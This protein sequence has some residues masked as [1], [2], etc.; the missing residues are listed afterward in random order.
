MKKSKSH[1]KLHPKKNITADYHTYLGLGIEKKTE[2]VKPRVVV[3]GGRK[4]T[5]G[6]EEIGLSEP[7]VAE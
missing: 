1:Q 3:A 7:T 5:G 4:T 6:G 2:V